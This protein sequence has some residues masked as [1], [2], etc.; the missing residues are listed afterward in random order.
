MAKKLDL[1]NERKYLLSL[2]QQGGGNAEWAKAQAQQYA[3]QYPGFSLDK[4]YSTAPVATPKP[5]GGTT[6]G[7]STISR[8]EL[9]DNVTSTGNAAVNEARRRMLDKQSS[10]SGSSYGTTPGYNYGSPDEV[11]IRDYILNY[12]KQYGITNKDIGWDGSNVLLGG[13]R[14]VTPSRIDDSGRSWGDINVIK[15]AIDNYANRNKMQPNMYEDIINKGAQDYFYGGQDSI[16]QWKE[17][18]PY[19]SPY[20][21]KINALLKKLETYP[22]FDSSTIYE[23]PEYLALQERTGQI[24]D[25]TRRN[26]MADAAAMTGGMPSSY[27]LAA[28][29]SAEGDIKGKLLDAVP[30]LTESA[31]GRYMDKQLAE[32]NL[33]QKLEELDKEAYGRH[34]GERAWDR[35][36]YESDRGHDY[37]TRQDL[38]DRLR[39]LE[40]EKYQRAIDERDYDRG[41]YESDRAFNY[42]VERDGKTFDYQVTRDKILD[43]RWMK[44]FDYNEAQDILANALRN[45]Q[46]TVAERNATLAQN[47]FEWEKDPTNPENMAAPETIGALYASMFASENPEEWLKENAQYLSKDEL[48]TLAGFLPSNSEAVQMM[49]VMFPDGIWGADLRAGRG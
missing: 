49:K 14:L 7:S 5:S 20:S 48:K 46:I 44:Q 23:S 34:Y 30:A 39:S 35:S 42:Q 43:E 15:K 16:P 22:E 25:K 19:V 8:Q 28:A 9:Y 13:Q 47:K 37:Q 2:I 29:A 38:L 10:S 17:P 31:Y 24:A 27:A 11:R 26:T 36:I 18:A 21:D 6:P 1:E 40:S 41:T 45:R 4:P 3:Q 32:F 33:L 12:G